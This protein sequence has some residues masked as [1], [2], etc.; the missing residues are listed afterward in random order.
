MTRAPR[1]RVVDKGR[2]PRAPELVVTTD[3]QSQHFDVPPNTRVEFRGIQATDVGFKGARFWWYLA[4]SSTFTSCDFSHVRIEAGNLGMDPATIYRRC[5]FDGADLRNAN[6]LFARFEQC[7][8]DGAD[9][10]G[11][12]SFYAEFV[13]CHFAGRIVSAK[14]FGRPEGLTEPPPLL[15]RQTNEFRGNDF[16][17]AELIDTGFVHGIEIKAQQWPQS[18]AYVM[19][20]RIHERIQKA[21]ATVL[22]WQDDNARKEALLMFQIYGDD[23]EHQDGLFARRDDVPI[24]P[25]VRDQAW[26]LLER[27]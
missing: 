16:R 14:F 22:S 11:F 10:R 26:D 2:V 6:P 12:R 20:D 5:R 27:A 17:E 23:T 25:A 13:E 9:F 19:L 8:F 4:G 15:K 7:S 24:T 3:L 18:D 21:R 1:Y